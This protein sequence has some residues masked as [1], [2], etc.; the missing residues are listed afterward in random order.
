MYLYDGLAFSG[1]RLILGIHENSLLLFTFGSIFCNTFYIRSIDKL[2]FEEWF[3]SL[4]PVSC[5]SSD[6]PLDDWEMQ[7]PE[8][9]VVAASSVPVPIH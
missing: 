7:E 2:I 4:S 6:Q 3:N 1:V 5:F 8:G 9:Q